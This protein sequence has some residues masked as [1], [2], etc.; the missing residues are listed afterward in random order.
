[1]DREP[2]LDFRLKTENLGL[3]IGDSPHPK[4]AFARGNNV[5][6]LL[7]ISCCFEVVSLKGKVYRTCVEAQVL[8]ADSRYELV[9]GKQGVGQY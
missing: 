1:M 4:L 2:I 5:G 7:G 8:V 3:R 6:P 9:S